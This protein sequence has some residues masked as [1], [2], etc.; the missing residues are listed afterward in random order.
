MYGLEIGFSLVMIGSFL[1]A[2]LS[3]IACRRFL[4]EWV[5]ERLGSKKQMMRSVT[6]AI[7]KQAFK[8]CFMTRMTPIPFG[9]QNAI[10][11]LSKLD[12][13]TYISATVLGVFVENLLTVYFGRF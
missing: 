3:F 7:N 1:G 4:T 11:A 9:I 12:F 5:E 13:R 8:I 2:S 6:K 10:F